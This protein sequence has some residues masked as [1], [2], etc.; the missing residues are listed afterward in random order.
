MDPSKAVSAIVKELNETSVEQ[1][2]KYFQESKDGKD[3]SLIQ[4]TVSPGPTP[5][6][7]TNFTYWLKGSSELTNVTTAQ[8]G[9]KEGLWN[10][11]PSNL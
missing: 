7:V 3:I 4:F 6:S 10:K 9:L 2:N 11:N 8:T 5:E 1:Y